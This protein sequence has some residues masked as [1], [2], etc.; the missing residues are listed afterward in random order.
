MS[1][2]KSS[3]NSYNQFYKE[4]ILVGIERTSSNSRRISGEIIMDIPTDDIWNI[5]T[6]YDNLSSHVPNLVESKV[7]NIMD[8]PTDDIWNILTD[9]DN[10]SSHVPNLVESKVINNGGRIVGGKPRVYQRGAQSIFGFEFG[11]DV[12]MDMTEVVHHEQYDNE[13]KVYSIDF[14]CVDSQFF[15]QFDGSWILEEY[16]N[17][18]TMV[19]YIVDVRP[20][21]PVPVAALE[22]RIK[23]DVP[24][25]ILAVSKSARASGAERREEEL[26]TLARQQDEPTPRTEQQQSL[27]RVEQSPPQ[28]QSNPLQQL[29]IQ[30]TQNLERTA[31]SFLPTP[32]F[33][34]A[35]RAIK[36]MNNANPMAGA[37][38][39]PWQNVGPSMSL[40]AVR[41][42]RNR[43]KSTIVDWYEDETMAT[44]LKDP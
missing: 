34:T 2:I 33:S 9:Y 3:A 30:A 32:V 14:E 24:V 35:K 15:S 36:A 19:R 17:D 13:H 22:W 21:G 26:N 8:I 18:K 25:N 42:K 23:E 43:L 4:G 39:S 31:K 10:L 37:L 29:T 27:N 20:K 11:A 1:K 7:I 5:L 16:S 44:Y 28:P 6:D 38:G 41:R 12:T 40:N